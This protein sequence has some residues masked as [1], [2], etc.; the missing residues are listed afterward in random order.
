MNIEAVV[1]D[2]PQVTLLLS[3][4]FQVVTTSLTLAI[5]LPPHGVWHGLLFSTIRM[6]KDRDLIKEVFDAWLPGNAVLALHGKLSQRELA[7]IVPNHS[8]CYHLKIS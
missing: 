1:V 5:K 7:D 8:S 3:S 2:N 4:K 6:L